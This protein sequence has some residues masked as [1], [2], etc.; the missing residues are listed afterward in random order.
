[1]QG[2]PISLW[3][4]SVIWKYLKATKGWVRF[5]SEFSSPELAERRAQDDADKGELV[6]NIT[7]M[8]TGLEI[9]DKWTQAEVSPV[10][11]GFI[12][13]DNGKLEPAIFVCD[14]VLYEG[15]KPV[16]HKLP[17]PRNAEY[18]Q[19]FCD[20]CVGTMEHIHQYCYRR[21]LR[22]VTSQ[23]IEETYAV[24]SNNGEVAN[25]T[26]EGDGYECHTHRPAEISVA[27]FQREYPEGGTAT[28]T[29]LVERAAAGK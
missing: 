7:D 13:C 15:A 16:V 11:V 8:D 17:N 27:E 1:M 10:P 18:G 9:L 14:H 24:I 6:Q 2:H 29:R 20:K 4:G 28:V 19:S 22:R 21:Y 3:T 23:R 5:K 25:L 26:R 12:R